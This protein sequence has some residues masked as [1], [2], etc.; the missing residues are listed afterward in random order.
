MLSLYASQCVTMGVADAATPLGARFAPD[1]K[2]PVAVLAQSRRQGDRQG[3]AATDGKLKVG[4]VE[5]LLEAE[6]KQREAGV[7]Q[8]MSAAKDAAKRG[9]KDAA[10]AQY[11]G[12]LDQKCLFPKQ[13]KDAANELKKLGVTGVR[14]GARR[15]GLRSRD[16][17]ARSSRR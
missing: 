9:E 3:A 17:R 2:L 7:K 4:Q 15:A 5:K 8:A 14:R 13:A 12:V 10:I 1:E 11:R 6:M 16:G